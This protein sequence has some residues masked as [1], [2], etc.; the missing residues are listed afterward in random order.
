MQFKIHLAD[1]KI[2][3]YWKLHFLTRTT[4]YSDSPG[5]HEDMACAWHVEG[6]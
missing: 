6:T 5:T 4:D 2:K 1:T 3:H